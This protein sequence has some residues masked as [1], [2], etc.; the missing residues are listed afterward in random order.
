MKKLLL[1]LFLSFF[2]VQSIAGSC[3]DGSDPVRSISADGTYFVYNCGG[4]NEQSSSSTANSKTKAVAGIDIE[5]DP[6][7]DFFKPPQKP[8]PTGKLYSFGMMWQMADFNNDGYSDVIYIGAMRPENSNRTG[9]DTGSACGDEAC[10]GKKPL[11]SLFL[12]DVNHKLTYS[13]ELLIDNREDSGLSLARQPLIADF[14]NDKVFDFY[15]GDHG[16]GTHDGVRDSYFLSQPNGTWVESS[17]THLSH[18]N[19]V[20]FNHGSATGDIDN[21]GDMDIVITETN[22][23]T[24]T[25]LWCLINDGTGY[26]NKRKCGGIFSFALE[27]ADIDGDGYLDVLLGAHEYEKGIDFTGIVWNDGR[28]N[29]PKNNNT[30]LPQHKKKWST[31]PEVSAADLDNDGD[32]DIVYSR[33]GVLYVGT[34]IQIIENLGNKKFKDHGIIPLVE[35]P[36]DFIPK[37]EGNEWNDFIEMIKFRDLDKDGNIDLYLSSSM[38][39]KTDGMVLLNQ[40]DFNFELLLPGVTK[41]VDGRIVTKAPVSEEQRAEEQ[42]SED[43]FAEFEAQLEKELAAEAADA[44]AEEKR[45]A[46]EAAI[47]AAQE[48]KALDELAEFEAELEAELAEENKSSPLFDGR[49]RFNLFRYEDDEG[50]MKIGNGFVEIKNGEVIIDKDNR[51]LTT[52]STDLYDAFSGQI[53]K[54]GK[55]SA[56]M[57][58]DVLNGIDV[59]ELYVFNG[60]I[61]DKKI[62]GDPPY[63][64]SLKTYLL[65]EAVET[66]V[67]SPLFDG[68]YSFNLFRY[69]DDEDWQELGNGFVEIRNG[70]V[71]IDKDNSDLK[72]AS[73]DLYDTFSG[74]IDEKGNVSG[75]VELAYLFGKDH[76]DVFTLSGQIDKKIWGD[77]PRDDFFRVYMILVKK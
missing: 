19:F 14:N 28:G 21:D 77:N 5:N 66:V 36:D 61:K 23:K 59:L 71:T 15:V 70:E 20:V 40:G 75:S 43:E 60:S 9:E 54:E 41:I 8:Y 65:L 48:Q 58:L 74:Q 51:E 3:P 39:R 57:E 32:L 67:S 63:E 2:S 53:N 56:S 30:L 6:N 62:W 12:G 24:G 68:R 34:A 52:G 26:L 22:W 27:L 1:L 16:L 45:I 7:I 50:S 44:I 33:A 35:A 76:S 46:E 17:E 11:P 37:T 73:T 72:T 10:S 47:I 29:F 18:S 25:A 69:H 31:V 4:G 42:A 49:Y 38:S 13:P 64:N 55:V